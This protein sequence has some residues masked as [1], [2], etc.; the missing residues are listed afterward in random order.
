[1]PANARNK[2]RAG[3]DARRVTHASGSADARSAPTTPRIRESKCSASH[4]PSAAPAA[5]AAASSPK[6]LPSRLI[7]ISDAQT[8]ALDAAV[9]RLAREAQ[10]L[11]RATH[12]P[13]ISVQRLLDDLSPGLIDVPDS[14]CRGRQVQIGGANQ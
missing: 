4:P 7:R 14:A 6:S 8:Q 13:A 2:A 10:R 5:A 11:C 9:K 3:L 12:I 1:M